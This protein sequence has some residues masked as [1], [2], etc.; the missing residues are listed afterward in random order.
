MKVLLLSRGWAWL[1]APV[2]AQDDAGVVSGVQ[3]P[4][5]PGGLAEPPAFAPPD[6]ETAE[7]RTTQI[8]GRLRCPVCQGLS[9]A[10]SNADSAKTMYAR[11]GE[12]VRLG[13]SQEQIEDYFVD[14]YGEWVRL[15]PPAEGMHWIIWLGPVIAL[16]AGAGAVGLRAR[17]AAAP[18]A[19]AP[20]DPPPEPEADPY[21]Q[22]ILDELEGGT[23]ERRS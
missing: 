18:A 13:Y 7:Q 20:A 1:A 9:I 11:V 6:A 3:A 19:A 8:G 16:V 2:H 23:P 10:D 21:R 17:Q 5:V 12:L 22:R 4:A 15:A 14:R